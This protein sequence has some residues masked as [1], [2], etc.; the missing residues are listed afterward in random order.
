MVDGFIKKKKCYKLVQI[1]FS[2]DPVTPASVCLCP[3][4]PTVLHYP[5][6]HMLT[7]KETASEYIFTMQRGAT[8]SAEP[9]QPRSAG[10]IT[11]PADCERWCT[12]TPL[13]GSHKP[14]C[15]RHQGLIQFH[16]HARGNIVCQYLR[17][18]SAR[19]KRGLDRVGRAGCGRSITPCCFEGQ[20]GTF[21]STFTF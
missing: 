19:K 8:P 6:V 2:T 3:F 20:P 13:T 15:L 4:P 10:Y 1:Q 11:R 14:T 5:L 21:W 18:F 16:C 9:Q 17:A 12:C 7:G